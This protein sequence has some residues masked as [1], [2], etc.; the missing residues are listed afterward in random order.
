MAVVIKVI[1]KKT[2]V[3]TI[4]L[5]SVMFL[6][7]CG[8]YR[9]YS[10]SV[11]YDASTYNN[12]IKSSELNAY[13]ASRDTLRFVLRTP[14]GLG[15]MEPKAQV[16]WNTISSQIEKEIIRKGHI[17]KDRTLLENLLDKGALMGSSFHS[18]LNTDIIIELINIEFDV[19]NP[20]YDF[21]IRE[22]RMLSNFNNW[23]DL[24]FIDCRMALMEC[25][26]T[27]VELG[28][29]G[30]IFR[31]YVS[32]CDESNDFFIKVYE[33]QDGSVDPEREAFVGWNVN[34]VEFKSLTHSYDLNDAS[35]NKAISRLVTVLL[36]TLLP[37]KSAA[38]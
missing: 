33:N 19:P 11:Q 35:R 3:Y 6:S 26:I 12:I 30:G 14:A 24:E 22:K 31:F 4:L 8:S 15:E 9:I 28:D 17:I 5:T 10:G 1:M 38:K 18:A 2:V 16:Q 37:Q 21:A 7:G 27:L 36:E 23:K 25:R 34:R 32:G 20:T 13:M 29:I